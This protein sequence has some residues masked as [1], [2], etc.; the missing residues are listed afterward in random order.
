MMVPFPVE[1]LPGKVVL[2][3]LLCVVT[4]E[5]LPVDEVVIMVPFPI[6][7]LPGEE[8]LLELLC[9]VIEG[10]LPVDEVLGVDIGKVG[11]TEVELE[12]DEKLVGLLDDGP[13]TGV[14]EE[15]G[16]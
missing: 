11:F 14:V 16:R 7:A 2:L 13:E 4:E 10:M 9:V 6:G 1:G 8:V 3:E 15:V 5:I 12:V